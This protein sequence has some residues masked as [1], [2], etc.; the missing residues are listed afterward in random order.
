MV[1][2]RADEGDYYVQSNTIMYKDE[3]LFVTHKAFKR[4][5]TIT[6]TPWII[7]SDSLLF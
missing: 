5:D 3:I 6:H 2:S 4:S 7:V 1:S